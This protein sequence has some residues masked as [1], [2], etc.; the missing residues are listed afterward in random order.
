MQVGLIF[1]AVL[2][3]CHSSPTAPSTTTVTV[4]G[5]MPGVGQ[6]SQLTATATLTNST[7][8]DVT[9]QVTWSSS[10]TAVATVT[11]GGLLAVLASGTV[12]ITALYQNVSGVFSVAS[13]TVTGGVPGLGQTSQLTAVAALP[14]S[15]S[16]DVTTQA[17]WS[18]SN[19]AVATVTSNGVLTMLQLGGT[20]V[21]ATYQGLSGQLSVSLG[22]SSITIAGAVPDVGQASQLAA[23]ATLSNASSLDVTM[24]ANWSSSN[25][26]VATISP[27]GLLTVLEPGGVQ[28]TATLQ[29]ATGFLTISPHNPVVPPVFAPSPARPH[30]SP[31]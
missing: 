9:T 23:L 25:A 27:G 15:A 2:S 31:H 7:S 21:T 4:T 6:T 13:I 11:S 8:L 17:T 24:Q 10:N 29:G 19:P 3:A 14:G 18:S 30:S 16:Q 12:Q 26:E 28:I 20:Q 22:I 5:T 1:A